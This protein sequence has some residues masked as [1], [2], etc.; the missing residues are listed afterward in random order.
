MLRPFTSSLILP[1]VPLFAMVALGAWLALRKRPWRRTSGI[2]LLISIVTLWV[3]S[4]Q[5]AGEWLERRWLGGLQPLSVSQVGSMAKSADKSQTAIIVLGGGRLPKQPETGVSDLG[6]QAIQRLRYGVWLA[7]QTG[8]PLG[9]TGGINASGLTVSPETEG[10]IA[11]QIAEREYAVKLRWVEDRSRYTVESAQMLL[12]MLAKD[13]VKTAVLVTN[14]YHM[15]RTVRAFEQAAAKQGLPIRI[16]AAPMGYTLA[17]DSTAVSWL[18]SSDG[19]RDVRQVWR[20]MMGW[21]L[22][23]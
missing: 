16:V 21:V 17:R 12:P 5:G 11:A 6:L 14:A 20:E 3:S 23:R 13:G 10:Q 18:P 7:K 8:H 22:G 9:F 2:L 4:T 19:V 1:P 15:P